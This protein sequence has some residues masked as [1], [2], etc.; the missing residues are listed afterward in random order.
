VS[1]DTRKVFAGF[2]LGIGSHLAWPVLG[3]PFYRSGGWYLVIFVAAIWIGVTQWIY[4]LPLQFWLRKTSRPLQAKGVLIAGALTLLLNGACW[5]W[6][7]ISGPRIG[8]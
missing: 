6:F 3:L 8:G 5:G 7:L 1:D 2:L 4:L